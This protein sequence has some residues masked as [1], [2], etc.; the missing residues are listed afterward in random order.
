[1]TVSE[2]QKILSMFDP[3]E[4]VVVEV[5]YGSYHDIE[6]ADMDYHINAVRIDLKEE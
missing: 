3:E 2:L 6:S 1:M 4:E 5:I